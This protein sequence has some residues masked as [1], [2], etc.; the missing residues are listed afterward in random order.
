MRNFKLP[1]L[2]LLY[3]LFLGIGCGSGIQQQIPTHKVTRGK[4][5]IN[6]VETGELKATVS[7]TIVAP[8]LNWNY[9]EL[10]ILRLIDDG[11]EVQTGD[12]LVVFDPAEVQ[13]AIIDAQAEL[14]IAKAEYDKTEADQDSKIEDLKADLKMSEISHQIS[15]LDLEQASYEADIRKKEIEL[16]LEQSEISLKKARQ[17]IENQQKINQEE[18]KKLALKIEQLEAKLEDANTTLL[19]LT[20]TAPTPGLVII[21]RNWST[22]NKWQVDEQPWSGASIIS[23][24]DLSEIKAVTD[25]N[26]VDISKI[27]MDQPVRIKVDAAPDTVFTGKVI[28]IATLARKKDR[29]SNVKVFS[30]EVLIDGQHKILMPG[31]TVSC[32][33]IVDEITDVLSIPLD[34]FFREGSEEFIY[35]SKGSSFKKHP[36]KAGAQNNDYIIINEGLKEGDEV[37]LIDPT[38]LEEKKNSGAKGDK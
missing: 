19:K 15:K 13:K 35:L 32:D 21:E 3:G 18:L 9:G 29:D 31:M 14:D 2:I 8:T 17:E 36:V 4:F 27:K 34:G 16:Q 7:N 11:D 1:K 28:D 24:P 5:F 26:E 10:K 37:A 22:G 33:I 12:T 20:L 6:V 23:L 25:I 38:K 30:V